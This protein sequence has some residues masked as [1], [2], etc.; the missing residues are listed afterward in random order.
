MI[1]SEKIVLEFFFKGIF[2]SPL[3]FF[4]LFLYCVL[5]LNVKLLTPKCDFF[6]N[7]T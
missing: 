5:G 4:Q 7:L 6:V 2:F 3:S 1:T